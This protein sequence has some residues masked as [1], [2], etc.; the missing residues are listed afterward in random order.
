ML[1]KLMV[2]FGTAVAIGIAA[3]GVQIARVLLG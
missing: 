1:E 3:A 2:T